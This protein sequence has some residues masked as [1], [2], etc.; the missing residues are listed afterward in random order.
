LLKGGFYSKDRDVVALC[1]ILF[2]RLAQELEHIE[3][4]LNEESWNWFTRPTPTATKNHQK[5]KSDLLAF[6][7]QLV[8]VYKTPA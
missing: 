6:E 1:G 5:R 8:P 4:G 2:T 7:S 3:S